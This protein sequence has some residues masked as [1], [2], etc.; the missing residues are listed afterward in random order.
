[1]KA[2]RRWAYQVK[3]IPENQAEVIVCEGNFH[4]RTI[5]VTSFSS[6]SEYKEGFGPFT[7]G[8]KII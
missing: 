1:I 8:F 3:G 5:T 6:S 2:A 4:G 7:P